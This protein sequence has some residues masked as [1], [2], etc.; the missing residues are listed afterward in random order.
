MPL[1]DILDSWAFQAHVDGFLQGV[2]TRL[3]AGGIPHE[4]R[5]WHADAMPL[6]IHLSGFTSTCARVQQRTG[7]MT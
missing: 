1:M 7:G 4:R 6:S 3:L 5:G 2:N